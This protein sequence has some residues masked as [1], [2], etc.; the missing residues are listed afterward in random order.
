MTRLP[1]STLQIPLQPSLPCRVCDSSGDLRH[2]CKHPLSHLSAP[3]G[4]LSPRA[5]LPPGRV[6]RSLRTGP[7]RPGPSALVACLWAPGLFGSLGILVV[8]IA[9]SSEEQL[10][11]HSGKLQPETISPC[12]VR[13]HLPVEGP[14]LLISSWSLF[15]QQQPEQC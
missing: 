14:P 11:I 4:C 7:L 15:P 1:V 13:K 6:G 2:M 12:R 5:G 8:P 9:V 3:G 10:D